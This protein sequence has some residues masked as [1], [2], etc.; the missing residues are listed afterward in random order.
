MSEKETLFGPGRT[1]DFSPFLAPE[2][3]R[4][5]Q[6]VLN[7]R[8]GSFTDDLR[9]LARRWAHDDESAHLRA[10]CLLVADLS[11][12]GWD[13]KVDGEQITFAPPGLERSDAETV[14]DVKSRIR[15]GLLIS[16]DRQLQEP[17]VRRFLARMERRVARK[18]A[19]KTCVLD[20]VDDGADLA[21]ALAQ[22]LELPEDQRP[23][24][25]AEVVDPIVEVCGLGAKCADTGLDLI[26]V[27]RYFRHT[28]ALEYRSVPGRQLMFL[29]RNGARPN[30]PVMGIAMLASPVMRLK[31]R[32]SWIG[33]LR[34]DAQQRLLP[35][36]AEDGKAKPPEWS[37]A[38]FA[39]AMLDRI[40]ASIAAVRWDDL[41][42]GDD[43]AEPTEAAVLALQQKAAGAAFKRE[44]ELKAHF[45]AARVRGEPVRPLKGQLKAQA[46]GEIDWAAA[47]QDLLFVRKRAEALAALLFAKHVF[48]EAGLADAPEAVLPALFET[49]RGQRAIDIVLSE[50]RKAGL[51]S[52]IADISVCG[53]IAPYND[54]LGGKL[55][56][57]LLTS[58][59]VREAYA[60]R[61]GDQVSV[62]ASQMAGRP[63]TKRADL[64]LLTTTSLYGLGSSQYNRL[65]LSTAAYPDLGGDIRWVAFGRSL[66]GGYGTIHL[67]GDTVNALREI[68]LARH[69]A[70]R[71]NNRFGE[72]TSPR[73][74]Q[75]REGLE[76]LGVQSD[77]VLHHATPRIFYGC[78]LNPGARASLL[79]L[80]PSSD[81]A[82]AVAAIGDAWRRRWLAGRMSSAEVRKRLAVLGPKSVWAS[83]HADADGQI[84]LPLEIG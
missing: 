13:I 2:S 54:L 82:P 28:W 57:L 29:I 62:I 19:Q 79:G 27:W 49:T 11:E 31:A 48:L 18:G 20:L 7:T 32:D 46:D 3:R 37:A 41:T 24:R 51:S 23:A 72:G 56:T 71:V 52:R 74:R 21:R 66:T 50:M 8:G 39:H 12:Q 5:V 35:S 61:Y 34:E 38:D 40:E 68:G 55:V 33:W 65:A 42:D 75:V 69:D 36:E 84:Q 80:E 77:Q 81:N 1:R 25:L 10:I 22:I 73:L 70:R 59:E 43:I 53:A 30:R 14:E 47:S 45:E 15:R 26:D 83:L 67:S 63:V 4:I 6:D 78:E 76:A 60:E 16:R 17:S 64:A 44:Q 58:K 9:A